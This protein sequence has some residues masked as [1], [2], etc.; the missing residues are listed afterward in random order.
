MW[1]SVIC[2]RRANLQICIWQSVREYPAIQHGVSPAPTI[3]PARLSNFLILIS[4]YHLSDFSSFFSLS[5][6]LNL[7]QS[8]FIL[9]VCV[10]VCSWS[11]FFSSCNFGAGSR[12]II[13]SWFEQIFNDCIDLHKFAWN[14]AGMIS[15][16]S[17]KRRFNDNS[18]PEKNI[19]IH[20]YLC[21]SI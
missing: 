1:W 5:L 4:F 11:I 10:C 19:Y 18:N 8:K 21:V 15:I 20:T 3:F 13:D 14:G 17:N 12:W 2:I 7:N 9:C 16:D 6:S